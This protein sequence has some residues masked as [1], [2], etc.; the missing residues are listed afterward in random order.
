MVAF[1]INYFVS[2]QA[3][4]H[5]IV[6]LQLTLMLSIFF[7]MTIVTHYIILIKNAL[8][9]ITVASKSVCVFF[10]PVNK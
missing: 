6:G 5:V 3:D 10:C 2:P 1:L 9:N 7:Q 4:V 8:Q